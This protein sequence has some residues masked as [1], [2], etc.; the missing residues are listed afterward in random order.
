MNS[1]VLYFALFLTLTAAVPTNPLLSFFDGDEMSDDLKKCVEAHNCSV[2]K[3]VDPYIAIVTKHIEEVKEH[4]KDPENLKEST[5][6]DLCCAIYPMQDC[7]L[8]VIKDDHEC[9]NIVKRE[10]AKDMK[11]EL[12]YKMCGT[13]YVRDVP[14]CK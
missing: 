9:L 14:G 12:H 6:K 13:K 4:L 1:I 5:K 7:V 2:M 11:S 10:I 8:N 3:C